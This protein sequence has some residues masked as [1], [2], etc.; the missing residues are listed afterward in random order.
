MIWPAIATESRTSARKMKSWNAIWCAPIAASP[1][2][3]ATAP[4]STNEAMSEAVR[5][6]IHF[7]SVSTRRARTS[8]GR[9]SA[10]LHPAQDHDHEGRA[11][12]ELRDR[13]SGGGSCDPPVEPV[14]E[15][16]LEDD[17]HDVPGDHDDERRPQVG[18]PAQ[19]ALAAEREK[20]RREAD[21]GDAE[22]G[23]CVLRGLPLAAHERDERL[24]EH[25]DER[26]HRDPEPKGE[27]DRLRAEPPRDLG[28][29]R[30]ARA[31]DLSGRPVLEEVED[32]ERRRRGWSRRCRARRAA[33][34][35]DGRR[36]P[37]RRGG[38]A[39]PRR[40]RPAREPRA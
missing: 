19:V 31:R 9:A 24:C 5:R 26:R 32:R 29:A 13:G 34:V 28:S 22:I 14:D 37:C 2:R 25:R 17:V 1:K 39:A 8:R 38:R 3:V 36:W 6:K 4:A 23:D 7:P 11:H 33:I 18:D 40:V 16:H 10:A 35:R 30:P 12:P 20:G 21:R 27:P 15:E